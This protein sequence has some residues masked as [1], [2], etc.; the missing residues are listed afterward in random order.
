M[1][2]NYLK[3]YCSVVMRCFVPQHDSAFWILQSH[4]LFQILINGI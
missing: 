2:P 1:L 4:F 3:I